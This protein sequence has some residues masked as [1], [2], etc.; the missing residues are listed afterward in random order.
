MIFF[1]LK[2]SEVKEKKISCKIFEHFFL[3]CYVDMCDM[4][5]LLSPESP[6]FLWNT[7]LTICNPISDAH[8]CKFTKLKINKSI[9]YKTKQS[10]HE[11]VIFIMH[12][13]THIYNI[14]QYAILTE[15]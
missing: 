10:D 7:S 14:G 11:G 15:G 5:F 1:L 3:L 2:L 4:F 8:G 6:G 13:C 12:I 9:L